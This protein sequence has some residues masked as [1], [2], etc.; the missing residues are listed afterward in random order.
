MMAEI[1]LI[2]LKSESA[3]LLHLYS[4]NST[5]KLYFCFQKN[6]I[7]VVSIIQL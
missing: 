7:L 4:V 2:S 6:R 1:V 3:E 5:K